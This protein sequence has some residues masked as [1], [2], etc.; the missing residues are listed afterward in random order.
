MKICTSCRKRLKKQPP[1]NSVSEEF[2]I[3]LDCLDD[4]P[5][6]A[7]EYVS[8][9]VELGCLNESLSLI[10]IS[11]IDRKRVK[12]T[13]KYLPCKR[14]IL[15]EVLDKKFETDCGRA[16]STS[17]EQHDREDED[18]NIGKDIVRKLVQRYNE[19]NSKSQK[20]TITTIFGQ[21]LSRRELMDKFKSSQRMAMTA[22]QLS[23]EKGILST[24]NLKAGNVIPQTT[25]K[26]VQNFYKHDDVSRIMPGKKDCI[27]I[28]VGDGRI[29]LQKRLVIRNL[30]EIYYSFKRLYPDMRIGFSKFA[31]LRPK[32]CVLAGASGTHFVCVCR[33]HNNV[34][35][36]MY[37]S[38]IAEATENLEVTLKHYANVFALTICN[39]SLP[40]CNLGCCEQCPGSNALKTEIL[41]CFDEKGV[42]EIAYKQWTSTDRYTLETIIEPSIEFVDTFFEKLDTLKRHDFIAKQQSKFLNE[43]KSNLKIGE[44]LVLGD[45]SENF[46]FVVQDEAQSFHWSNSSA[47]IHPIVFYYKDDTES[48]LRNDNFVLISDSN[49]HYTVAV[50]LFQKCLIG[51]L[52]KKFSVI[53]K[54]IY[55]S[56]GCSGQYKNR[57]NF[58]N[59]CLH[60]DDFGIP[61]ERPFFATSHGKGPCNGLGGTIKREAT[62]A[63]MQRPYYNQILEPK[64][65]FDFIN[66]NLKGINGKYAT[67][68]DHDNESEL[69]NSRFTS[70]RAIPG[71]HR[72]HSFKPISSDSLKVSVYSDCPT[73]KVVSVIRK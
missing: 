42:D 29:K 27:S 54:I 38:R 47:T 18:N 37:G 39:P 22:K 62:K 26:L 66:T 63:S 40:A 69:L 28:K 33:I 2:S 65:L 71:T 30:K 56:D 25:V 13:G 58:L 70:A 36:M 64:H 21:S 19:V 3:D 31:M 55:F 16:P 67:V 9:E 41:E 12:A 17:K 73:Q 34:K 7:R 10:G 32:E 15:Q 68:G 61:A 35:L 44:F 60:K 52:Y 51:F 48:T 45:C 59:L 6:F 43:G 50:H 23:F 46:S 72:L 1:E 53:K 20:I 24:P 57:K 14:Q 5:N 8:P 4:D 11:P 49:V